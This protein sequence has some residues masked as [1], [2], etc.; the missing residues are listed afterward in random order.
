MR[1]TM[2]RKNSLVTI[3]LTALLL[4]GCMDMLD[5]DLTEAERNNPRDL[6]GTKF[7]NPEITVTTLDINSSGEV[8]IEWEGGPAEIS[9]ELEYRFTL[10]GRTSDWGQ[11]VRSYA[12]LFQNDSYT[13]SIEARYSNLP[14]EPQASTEISESFTVNTAPEGTSIVNYPQNIELTRGDEFTIYGFVLN[15]SDLVGINMIL[16]YPSS[17]FEVV[18]LQF[19][20]ENIFDTNDMES[21]KITNHY[22]ADQEME[23]VQ[24]A[25]TNPLVGVEGFGRVARATLRVLG[26]APEGEHIIGVRDRSDLRDSENNS[27]LENTRGSQIIVN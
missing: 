22:A 14:N 18:N 25:L 27:I 6:G 2:K 26:D 17:A 11:N 4:A 19:A 24:V 13:I 20:D 9:D 10:F 12:N 23:F 16:D 8:T 1:S 21:E 5:G 7:M 3:L 15:T